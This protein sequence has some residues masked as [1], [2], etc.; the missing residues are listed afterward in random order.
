MEARGIPRPP[1]L[2]LHM[3]VSCCGYAGDQT[4]SPLTEHLAFL[5]S[6]DDIYIKGYVG[7]KFTYGHGS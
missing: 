7:V 2:E 6:I 4:L 3:V 5:T 1:E